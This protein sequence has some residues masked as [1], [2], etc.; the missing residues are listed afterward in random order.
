MSPLWRDEVAIYLGPRKVALVRRPRGISSRISAHTEYT[1]PAG[2]F[3]DSAPAFARLGELLREPGWQNAAARVVIADPWARF[4]VVPHAG[5][6]LDAAARG[7]HARYVLVDNYGDGVTDWHLVTED[8]PPGSASVACAMPHALNEALEAALLPARLKLVSMQPLLVV[9]Y[10]AWRRRLPREDAWFVMIE[11][12]WL[13]AVRIARGAWDRIHTARLSGEPSV[14]LDR[15]QA[16]GRLTRAS[17]ETNRMF[18][19]APAAMRQ[20]AAQIGTDFEWLGADEPV[21]EISH[22]LGLLM[23]GVA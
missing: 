6:N 9:A 18:V 11:D 17:G 4:S 21:G 5:S 7:A 1:L 16:F 8:A 22:E 10:N 13:S 2:S 15:L 3:V 19:E 20:R 12:G 23:R 14:E